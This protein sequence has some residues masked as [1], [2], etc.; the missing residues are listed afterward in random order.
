MPGPSVA[1]VPYAFQLTAFEADRLDER[2]RLDSGVEAALG[3]SYRHLSGARQRLLRLTALHPGTDFDAPAAAVLTGG[4]LA[5]TASLLESLRRDH[6]LQLQKPGRYTIHD[7]VRAYAVGRGLDEDPPQA[8]RAALTRLF[9]YYLGAAAA[10]MD[11]LYA[12]ERHRRPDVPRSDVP[13]L[14]DP[15]DATQWLDTERPNLVSVAAWRTHAVRLSATLFRYLDRH[16]ADA[17]EIHGRAVAAARAAGKVVDE[18]HV[19][20]NLGNAWLGLGEPGRASDHLLR[21]LDLLR[22]AGDPVGQA[23]PLSALG[24]IA[25]RQGRYD[26]AAACF[27]QALTLCRQAG[28][29]FGEARALNNLGDVEA[30]QGRYGPGAEHLRQALDML[31]RAGDVEGEANALDTLGLLH[32]LRGRPE[33]A[34]EPYRRALA[35]FRQIGQRDRE[36]TALNGQGEAASVAGDPSDAVVRHRQALALAVDTGDL[37]E[38]ARARAGLDRARRALEQQ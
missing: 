22:D 26:Q 1:G 18:G 35:L 31:R 24:I 37:E 25:A 33:D 21:S 9:D 23:R 7:L 30:R 5:G 27:R 28:D 2:R 16:H 36:A 11:I 29:T 8:R 15:A 32:T 10:A 20:N 14:S 6:L 19:L 12:A 3:L 38:Q 34:R 4:D 13:G 17:A